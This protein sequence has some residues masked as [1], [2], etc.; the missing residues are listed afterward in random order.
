MFSVKEAR[1]EDLTLPAGIK[2]AGG[3]CESYKE[4]GQESERAGFGK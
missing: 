1:E 3:G 2:R 4:T